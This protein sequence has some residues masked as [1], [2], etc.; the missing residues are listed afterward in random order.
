MKSFTNQAIE[1]E[2]DEKLIDDIFAPLNQSDAPGAA[3]G[4]AID[5]VPVYRKGFGLA[6]MELPI[7]LSPTIRMRLGSTTKHF[8]A[9][10]YMLLC[11]QGLARPDDTIGKHLPELNPIIHGITVRQ[12]MGNIGGLREAIDVLTQFSGVDG[13]RIVTMEEIVSLYRDIDDLNTAPGSTYDYN[14]GGWV[15]VSAIIERV[16]GES[17]ENTM[18]H[19]VFEPIGMYDSALRRWDF[20]CMRNSA[21]CHKAKVSPV[22]VSRKGMVVSQQQ[23]E[24]CE[25][26]GGVDIAGAGS[27]VSTVDDMLRWLAHMDAPR[28][29][30]ADTWKAM[31]TSQVLGNGTSTDYGLGL[32]RIA[33]RGVETLQ[34]GGGCLGN[35][36]QMLKVPAA[37]LDLIVMV[38]RSDVW[39]FSFADKVLDACLPRLQ[40]V[41]PT[42]TSSV[43]TGLFK[44][45]TSGRV[46]QLFE[47]EEGQ[48]MASVDFH[49]MPMV[50]DETGT[51]RTFGG[52]ATLKYSME[53]LGNHEAP[54]RLRFVEFGNPDEFARIDP[55]TAEKDSSTRIVGRYVSKTLD[56]M[57]TISVVD[58]R[59]RMHSVGRFGQAWHN[60]E[61]MADGIWRTTPADINMLP[62]WGKVAL[63]PDGGIV[64]SNA[65]NQNL[66]FH[67]AT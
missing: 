15:I 54:E 67:R 4:I 65:C 31:R 22:E 50:N 60:L 33:Y 64:F 12:L 41:N 29:G 40:S 5:G 42:R 49:E 6:N 34:H 25:P 39:S 38:N 21:T 66:C 28:V 45:E 11:E 17:L 26:H 3:V 51:L 32:Q 47:G 13:R 27:V 9:F 16:A 62:P 23:Y 63:A 1:V 2:F 24:K 14:N 7:T 43:T 8:T 44:S 55:I 30:S 48:Q 37:N 56:T 58:E 59:L 18:W 57:L 53:L 35:N 36:V 61:V 46:I 52:F 10:T 19:H 20:L